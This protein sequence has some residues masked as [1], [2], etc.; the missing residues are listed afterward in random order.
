MRN[1]EGRQARRK[2]QIALFAVIGLAILLIVLLIFFLR[3]PAATE[4]VLDDLPPDYAPIQ[5]HIISCIEETTIDAL[6]RM[7]MHGGYLDPQNPAIA[8]R[9]LVKARFVPTESD[10]V[11]MNPADPDSAVP[12]YYYLEGRNDC[13]DCSLSTLTPGKRHMEQQV[14]LYVLEHLDDC[15]NL[16]LFNDFEI[17]PHDRRRLLIRFF[18]ESVYYDYQRIYDIRRGSQEVQAE[19]FPGYIRIPFLRYYQ[20]ARQITQQEID[21]QFLENYL[22]YLVSA[23]SGID[24]ELPPLG[25]FEE[26]FTPSF[27]IFYTVQQRYQQLLYSVTPTLQ[28]L[29]T[30]DVTPIPATAD[31]FLEGFF[32]TTYLDLLDPRL[33][34]ER[35]SVSFHYLN[36]P[37]HFDVKPR[38]GQ[39]IRPRQ[40][41]QR[42]LFLV[43]SRQLNFYDFLYDISVPFV[44]EIRH[45][46][47]IESTDITFLFA[48]EANVRD[49]KNLALW[50]LGY[51]TIPWD[52]D[53][54]Q[55]DITDPATGNPIGPGSD[56]G[57]DGI[58]WQNGSVPDFFCDPGLATIPIRAKTF[59]RRTNRPLENVTF[60]FTCGYY[61][62]CA[63][64]MSAM[65]EHGVYALL[66]TEL[67]PCIGGIL[68]AEKEGYNTFSLQVSTKEG[69]PPDLPDIL[70]DPLVTRS[71]RFEKRQ[72]IENPLN[73]A[74]SVEPAV[75]FGPGD[76]G[77]V[78]LTLKPSAFGADPVMA[79]AYTANGTNLTE[80]ELVPG[81]YE[82]RG[83][84]IY[85]PGFIIPK[86][87]DRECA[88]RGMTGGCDEWL[89]FP[90]NETEIRPAPWGGNELTNDTFYWYLT[91]DVLYANDE[92]VI[93]LF[94]APQ[95]PACVDDLEWMGSA[96][97]FS[98][99]FRAEAMPRLE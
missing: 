5:E 90:E 28:V 19:S 77:I 62:S 88:D 4:T 23:Y 43:P 40:E 26:S 29:G 10:L 61:A 58:Y 34:P 72:V 95:P 94:V 30:K 13:R 44:V 82:V 93:P 87:C 89:Y 73:S 98:R 31:P 32:R 96:Q 37:I 71:V 52:L 17:I 22:L 68:T 7:A 67:P 9:S 54:V 84:Y 2:G 25:G 1:P 8:G 78:T 83:Q 48:L 53:V 41:R 85:E 56:P 66:E 70:L 86:E 3:K 12:Y 24:G 20:A 45:E 27:W 18:N 92:V 79:T 39:L 81:L 33:D 21:T 59:D 57:P 35:F 47:A 6:K 42:G 11:V 63:G 55:F 15:V 16:Q 91:R 75:P 38:S 64:G 69:V 65:D 46:D 80:V 60:T 99:T 36:H 76:M 97:R 49:N 50:L 74:L 14:E 51:G